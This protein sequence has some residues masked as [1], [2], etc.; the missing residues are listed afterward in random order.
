MVGPDGYGKSRLIR[1][2][3]HV[4]HS[5][6]DLTGGV[7]LAAPPTTS[8]SVVARQVAMALSVTL[9]DAKTVDEAVE[10]VGYAI[11]DRGPVLVVIDGLREVD[12]EVSAV[13]DRWVRLAPQAQ[14]VVSSPARLRSRGEVA[15][16][17]GPLDMPDDPLDRHADA[18]R[19]LAMR[20]RP[21]STSFAIGGGVEVARLLEAVGPKPRAIRLLAGLVDRLERGQ[22]LEA[23][24]GESARDLN[25]VAWETLDEDEQAVLAVCAMHWGSFEAVEPPVAASHIDVHRTLH[26]LDRRGWL[27]VAPDPAAPDVRRYA[28]DA[29][30]RKFVRRRYPRERIEAIRQQR[31]LHLIR[32]CEAWSGSPVPL[33]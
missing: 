30:L 4:R 23:L 13:V 16:E 25:E 20:A 5:E 11:A 10:R 19:L 2:F 28:L 7:W 8:V 24:T 14:F 9:I 18:I 31:S 33:P 12:P 26:E 32:E 1:Q 29:A 17:I 27:R 21:L 15:Y 22:L 6:P 3:A